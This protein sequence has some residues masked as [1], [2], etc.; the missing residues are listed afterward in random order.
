VVWVVVLTG[1]FAQGLR[2]N[3]RNNGDPENVIV[4]SAKAGMTVWFS[5]IPKSYAASLER[6][7][8]VRLA[9]TKEGERTPCVSPEVQFTTELS[10]VERGR[11]VTIRGIEP[12]RAFLV[13]AQVHLAGG[14]AP[15]ERFEVIV[16]P[17]VA[18]KLGLP[19]E[20]LAIGQTLEFKDATWTITGHFE[21]PGTMFESEIW[22]HLDNVMTQFD[23]T[24]YALI[25]LKAADPGEAAALCE[26]MVRNTRYDELRAYPEEVFFQDYA[27]SFNRFSAM[28]LIGALVIAIGG[29]CTGLNTM[30]ASVAGR[31][32]EMGMLQV[33]GFGRRDILLAFLVES[34][35]IALV[36]GALGCLGGLL[37]HGVP[38]SITWLAF[39]LHVDALVLAAGAASALLIGV[40][41]GLLPAWRGCRIPMI[42][43]MRHVG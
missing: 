29:V 11:I 40:L 6:L 43:A 38:L 24:M 1:A 15:T 2:Q 10:G 39:T 37:F 26:R 19:P 21:A 17:L 41:G 27:S 35:C 8:G 14:A 9:E 36:G 22:C 31:I 13:N 28:A 25:K 42:D 5:E 20:R 16:G 18:A 23:R 30:Y 3:L 32:R 7:E 12:S 33:L 34:L 4:L